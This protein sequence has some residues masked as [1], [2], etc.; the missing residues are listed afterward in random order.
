M[1]E[2]GGHWLQ[3]QWYMRLGACLVVVIIVYTE[4]IL[5]VHLYSTFDA[6][7]RCVITNPCCVEKNESCEAQLAQIWNSFTQATP[8]F[9]IV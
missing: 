2:G 9:A 8:D 6:T 7:L 4:D 5:T 1:R 3:L